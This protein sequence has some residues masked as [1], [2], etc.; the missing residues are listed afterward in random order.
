MGIGI[1]AKAKSSITAE[2]LKEKFPA[3]AKTITPELVELINTANNDPEFNGNEF[4]DTMITYQGVMNKNKASIEDFVKAVKFCAYLEAEEGNYT[5]AYIKSRMGEEF[6]MARMNQPTDSSLYKQLTYAASRYRSQSPIVR[7]LLIQASMPEHL[8]YR[9]ARHAAFG[10]LYTEMT[11][12]QY[13]KDRINAADKLLVHTAPPQEIKMELDIG[14]KEDSIIDKY[15]SMINELVST[16]KEKIVA[17]GDLK[18]ITNIAIIKTDSSDI[19][20][21]DED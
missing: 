7:D 4:I 15:K 2:Y 5:Q 20:D 14:V 13:S 8:L 6:V 9:S 21:V 3:K 1:V 10:T 16:Q 11:T 18:A 17:G 19:I 12:A